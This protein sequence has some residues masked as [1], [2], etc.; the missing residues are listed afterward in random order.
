MSM[1]F[2]YLELGTVA[3]VGVAILFI[4]IPVNAVGSDIIKKR[5]KDQMDI[6]DERVKLMNEI[7][8]G[9]K[10]GV[11]EGIL[12]NFDQV[13]EIDALNALLIGARSLT[14]NK[15]SWANVRMI[16]KLKLNWA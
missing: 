4:L 13:T 12:I 1:Y 16:I 7:L 11:I 3:F 5:R 14:G 10:V 15:I 8:S 6:K 2:L 9:M